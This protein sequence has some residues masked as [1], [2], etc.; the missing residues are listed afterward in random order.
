MIQVLS[1]IR[2]AFENIYRRNHRVEVLARNDEH[3]FDYDGLAELLDHLM[4]IC[5]NAFEAIGMFFSSTGVQGFFSSNHQ[6]S[7]SIRVLVNRTP[8]GPR[9]IHSII[10]SPSRSTVTLTYSSRVP[11]VVACCKSV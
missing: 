11:W 5:F 10:C 7:G 1:D 9:G 6:R 3:Q 2:I 8:I 4:S